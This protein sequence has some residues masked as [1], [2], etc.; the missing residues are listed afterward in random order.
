MIL[1]KITVTNL[2]VFYKSFLFINPINSIKRLLLKKWNLKSAF[3]LNR[4]RKLHVESNFFFIYLILK[5]KNA[6]ENHIV[7]ERLASPLIVFICKAVLF[8][9]NKSVDRASPFPA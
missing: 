4:V 7:G 5:R 3:K 1:L 6:K 9:I 8:F 2:R